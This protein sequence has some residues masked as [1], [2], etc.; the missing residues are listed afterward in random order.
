LSL[1]G[2]IPPELGGSNN[3]LSECGDIPDK[4]PLFLIVSFLT[5][6]KT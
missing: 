1:P 5:I 6:K 4:K 3:N 2:T